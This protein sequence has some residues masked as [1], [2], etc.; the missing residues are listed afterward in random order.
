MK[1]GDFTVGY[2][3]SP[4]YDDCISRYRSKVIITAVNLKAGLYSL[5]RGRKSKPR[6]ID[7]RK[8]DKII[9]LSSSAGSK[10]QSS[11]I[12]KGPGSHREIASG[13]AVERCL[14]FACYLGAGG[15]L[16]PRTKML[17]KRV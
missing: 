8:V 11:H 7:R 5:V 4:D 15:S 17:A 6:A 2:S 3:S 12:K 9:V 13:Q 16:W 10:A 1:S 14:G